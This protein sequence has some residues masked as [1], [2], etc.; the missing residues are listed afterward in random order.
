MVKDVALI[1][2]AKKNTKTSKIIFFSIW[3]PHLT[4]VVNCQVIRFQSA[5]I[6][7]P[8]ALVSFGHV[9]SET[10]WCVKPSGSGDENGLLTIFPCSPHIVAP[11]VSPEVH[12]V[13]GT[14]S[15]THLT[16]ACFGY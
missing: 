6:L 9:V 12:V 4:C 14:G 11:G 3:P 1:S 5:N 8:R 16:R 2:L 7:V 10:K 15:G 13:K